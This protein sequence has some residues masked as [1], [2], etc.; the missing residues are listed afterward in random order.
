METI[1]LLEK[2]RIAE[3]CSIRSA[4]E[5]FDKSEIAFEAWEMISNRESFPAIDVLANERHDNARTALMEALT[6][7]GHLSRVEICGDLEEINTQVVSR[8]LNGWDEVLPTHEK[9]RRFAELC[10]E[11]TIQ[12]VHRAIATG[13]MPSDTAV[14][15]VSDYPEAMDE[16]N[17]TRF[18]YRTAN[19]KGMIRSTHLQKNP[20]GS[21]TRVIEQVS[22]SNSTWDSTAS[23]L[24]EYGIQADQDIPDIA[25]LHTPLIFSTTD[26]EGGVVDLVNKL[27]EHSGLDV[28]YGDTKAH[29]NHAPYSM[30]RQESARRESEVTS[31]IDRLAQLDIQL[32]ALTLKGL[33]IAERDIIYKQEVDRMLTAIC[34]VDPSYAVSTYGEKAAI[35]FYEAAQLVSKGD[36]SRAQHL[37]ESTKHLRQTVTFCGMSISVDAAKK[38]GLE[39]NTFGDL[40]GKGKESWRWKK[41][42]CRVKSCP[43][44]PGSTMVGPCSVCKSCQIQFDKGI[45]P[46]KAKQ[47]AKKLKEKL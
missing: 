38:M 47:T 10:E 6:A 15:V 8:L 44:R 5:L 36:I 34:T 40:I 20:D 18:G 27:D 37:L 30:L 2:E 32:G 7:S 43:T 4:S 13:E 42:V 11:L 16:D 26:Y 39:V 19:K 21:Y 41:G 31:Y 46:T 35:Y 28:L 17:A 12:R 3:D 45:D 23:F 14:A 33:T 29:N 24:M 22:R 1:Q 25:V 9:L